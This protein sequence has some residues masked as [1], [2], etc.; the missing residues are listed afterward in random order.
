MTGTN[1]GAHGVALAADGKLKLFQNNDE[2]AP[3]LIRDTYRV[4]KLGT[5][6]A[7]RGTSSKVTLRFASAGLLTTGGE[8]YRRVP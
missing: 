5:Q 2:G 1:P 8:T 7:V 3:S 4:G 6:I